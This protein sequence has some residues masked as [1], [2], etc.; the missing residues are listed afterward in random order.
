MNDIRIKEKESAEKGLQA[1][2]SELGRHI[3]AFS[4]DVGPGN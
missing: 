3:K 1:L 4:E 2:N